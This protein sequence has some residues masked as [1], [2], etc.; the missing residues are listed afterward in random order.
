MYYNP[1]EHMICIYSY[2]QNRYYI[3]PKGSYY[4]RV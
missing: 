4:F 2:S 1:L 3:P